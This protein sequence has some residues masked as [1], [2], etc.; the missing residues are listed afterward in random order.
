[1]PASTFF[2]SLLKIAS[3]YKVGLLRGFGDLYLESEDDRDSGQAKGRAAMANGL[4]SYQLL[5]GNGTEVLSKSAKKRRNRKARAEREAEENGFIKVNKGK[6][7]ASTSP[8]KSQGSASSA[9][10]E[11]VK[12]ISIGNGKER[13]QGRKK[14]EFTPVQRRRENGSHKVDTSPVQPVVV[15][16][17]VASTSSKTYKRSAGALL[18]EK[19]LLGQSGEVDPQE[20]KKKL[21]NLISEKQGS[22]EYGLRAAEVLYSAS[23]DIESLKGNAGLQSKTKQLLIQVV[24]ILAASDESEGKSSTEDQ[25]NIVKDKYQ[26]LSKVQQAE[27]GP[28]L[29][30]RAR[31]TSEWNKIIG[32]QLDNSLGGVKE[33]PSGRI[34]SVIQTF[35]SSCEGE[36]GALISSNDSTS[37]ELPPEIA[38]IDGEISVLEKKLV[39]L[40]MRKRSLM[41]KVRSKQSAEKKNLLTTFDKAIETASKVDNQFAG[42]KRVLNGGSTKTKA[43][44]EQADL[45]AQYLKTSMSLTACKAIQQKELSAKFDFYVQQ[46][47][48]FTTDGNSDNESF[49]KKLTTM[50]K[51]ALNDSTDI[52]KLVSGIG[53]KIEKYSSK[54]QVKSLAVA[55]SLVKT[56]YDNVSKISEFHSQTIESARSVSEI[57]FGSAASAKV[58]DLD[59][60]ATLIRKSLKQIKLTGSEATETTPP[61]KPSKKADDSIA[62]GKVEA[63]EKKEAVK[64]A[65]TKTKKL[66]PALAPKENAWGKSESSSTLFKSPEN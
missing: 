27:S 9:E 54:L 19:N 35:K 45:L 23:S 14:E 10:I 37:Y 62:N 46:I 52:C 1:M 51:N 3:L 15:V 11:V 2:R 39:E 61:P 59:Q 47:T 48:D 22:E 65:E 4:N 57:D 21:A 6:A 31:V 30:E 24:T 38:E 28:K 66:A 40:K 44:T 56:F 53:S 33:D 42:L 49:V 50:G 8:P 20:L 58:Q 41:E 25:R 32:K 7:I 17:Q 13:K 64:E 43:T 63:A 36:Q 16:D 18:F 60:V 34:N 26:R 5:S 12:E 29:L 55:P